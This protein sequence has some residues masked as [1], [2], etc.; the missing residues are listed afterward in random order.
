MTQIWL[1]LSL[2]LASFLQGV[3]MGFAHVKS[4]S[5]KGLMK[6]RRIYTLKNGLQEFMVDGGPNFDDQG[7]P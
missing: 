6:L 5:A 1:N 3:G 2:D 4:I 7:M